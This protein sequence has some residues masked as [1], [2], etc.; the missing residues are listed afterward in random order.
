MVVRT[1]QEPQKRVIS[2]LQTLLDDYLRHLAVKGF[3]ATTLRVRRVHI[4]MFLTWCRRT[5]ITAPNQVTATSLENYQRHLFDYRKK[6]GQPL[7]IASQ[8]A[9]LAP[10]KLWF[11]WMVRRNYLSDD[12][13]SEL[14]LPRVGYKLPCVLNKEE[15]ELVL[16][17]PNLQTVIGLRDRAILETLYSTGIRRGELLHLRL[18]DIDAKHGLVTVREGKGKRDRVVPI[19]ERALFWLDR[20]LSNVRP[21]MVR[22]PHETVVFLSAGG[23][24]FAPNHLSWLARRYVVAAGIGKSGACHIFRHTMA[25][26]MLEGGADIRYIQAMLGHVRLDTTKIYTHVSIRML[27]QI[28]NATHPAARLEQ[29]FVSVLKLRCNSGDDDQP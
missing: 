23:Q 28:H 27:K 29:T 9:R 7:A 4:E 6:D 2:S 3:A 12:P 18:Y 21:K 15:A 17:Q 11:K 20:Y 24:P 22:E 10:L 19:G 14:E 25:T 5:Q 13:S 26:L 1:D 16:K 8:H